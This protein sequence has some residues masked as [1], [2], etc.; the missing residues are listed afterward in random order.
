MEIVLGKGKK[1]YDKKKS[2]KERDIN[3]DTMRQI[4]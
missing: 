4:K 1:L 3:R 2:L